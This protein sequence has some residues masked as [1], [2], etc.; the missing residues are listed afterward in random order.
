MM[1]RDCPMNTPRL[2]PG[3]RERRLTGSLFEFKRDPLALLERYA[4]DYGDLARFHILTRPVYLV[5]HP[6]YVEQILGIQQH[7]FVKRSS[8]HDVGGVFGNGMLTSN[9]NEWRRQRRTVSPAFHG[10]H[11]RDY[12]DIIVSEIEQW[13]AGWC[14]GEIRDLH[15]E[16]AGLSLVIVA[17]ALFGAM[18]H[19]DAETLTAAMDVLVDRFWLECP[20]GLCPSGLLPTF[21]PTRANLQLRRSIREIDR[22]AYRMLGMQPSG[23][24]TGGSLLRTLLNARD[25]DGKPISQRQLRDELV[26]VL[27]AGHETTACA[28]TWSW[29]L[30]AT[31]PEAKRKVEAEVATELDEDV[32]ACDAMERLCYTRAVVL[33]SMRLYPPVWGINRV[34][35]RDCEI[36]GHLFPKGTSVIMSQWLIHHDARFYQQPGAFLPERWTPEFVA[37]LPRY[38]YFP[39]GGGQRSCV[40]SELAML[41]LVLT[42]AVIARHFKIE[43]MAREPVRPAPSITLRPSGDLRIVLHA[44]KNGGSNRCV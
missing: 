39:F 44:R 33:E 34:T 15:R 11:L 20:I 26:T 27:L 8:S 5:S 28:L 23:P 42:L 43:L 35:I 30:L 13:I 19:D 9:G 18:L 36:G 14:D 22:V 2:P 38:A 10:Q 17:R 41:E 31:N 32:S 16:M 25:A 1:Q 24:Q 21:F 12:T 7:S 40:G 37:G 4:R 6:S 3:P 29:Y